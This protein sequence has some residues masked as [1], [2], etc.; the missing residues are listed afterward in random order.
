MSKSVRL[1][2]Q[3]FV[4]ICT[5]YRFVLA[6]GRACRAGAD[7]IADDTINAPTPMSIYSVTAI[8]VKC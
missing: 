3:S 6:L 2:S 1:G 7:T 4:K 8:V 5:P